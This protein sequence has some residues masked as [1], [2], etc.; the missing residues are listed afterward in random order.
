[1]FDAMLRGFRA[2]QSA[3]GLRAHT[4]D[5]R[6][7]LVRRFS[8]FT[9]EYPWSWGPCHVDEWTLS[10][11]GEK[12]LA[13]STI[14]SYQVDL[15]LFSRYITDPRY[16]WPSAC[17][18]SF[19]PGMHPVAICHEW[20]TMVHLNDYEG[21]P[22]ARPFTREELQAFIDYADEQVERSAARKRKGALSAYRDATLFKVIYAWGLRR[23]ETV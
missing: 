19:G 20:N 22:E 5:A 12:H 7:R 23:T 16:G 8:G 17:E 4:I 2:Q 15:R 6:E 21:S 1:M 14:R 10:L 18:E 3:R 9:N 11:T 13:P